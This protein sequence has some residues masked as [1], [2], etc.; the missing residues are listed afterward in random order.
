MRSAAPLFLLLA[1]TATAQPQVVV[2]SEVVWRATS[3]AATF[4]PAPQAAPVAADRAGYVVA[5]SEVQDGVSRAFAGRLDGAGRLA[6]VGVRTA[7]TADAASIV[8]FAGRYIAAWLEPEVPDQRPLLVTAA[9][10]RDFTLLSA[11]DLGL[12]LGPPIVRA[13]GSRVLLNSKSRLYEL[14]GDAAVINQFYATRAI[15]DF[16]VVGD[17]FGYVTHSLESVHCP[18]VSFF[19]RYGNYINTYTV[20]FT[21]VYR[22]VAGQTWTVN[23]GGPPAGDAPT[24]VG[25]SGDQYLIVYFDPNAQ[26]VKALHGRSPETPLLLSTRIPA[27]GPMTQAQVAWDGRRWLAVWGGNQSVEAAVVNGDGT[28]SAFTISGEGWR[29][30]VTAASPGRF[31]VTYETYAAPHRRL[32]SRVIT[33]S[34]FT[35]RERAVRTP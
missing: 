15:D 16:A 22:F 11:H 33:F 18:S 21:W 35:Q 8:P 6:T 26:A 17:Q 1:A 4:Y 20:G 14:N 3:P 2:G 12:S 9:L 32:A 27:L 31:L 30:A 10:D 23:S 5:W 25:M 13:T 29:P 28:F 34:D 24:A 7:G 19:C